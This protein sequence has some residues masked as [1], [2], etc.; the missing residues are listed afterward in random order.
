MRLAEYIRLAG[1]DP[2]QQE[3]M[4]INYIRKHGRIKRAE[5]MDLCRI[6]KDQ[7]YRLLKRLKEAGEIVQIGQLKGTFYER[8]R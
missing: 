3:Q 5:A 7:A 8:I 1:F 4:V 2:I 6:T